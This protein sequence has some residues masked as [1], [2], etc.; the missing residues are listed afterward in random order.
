MVSGVDRFKAILAVMLVALTAM[1]MATTY[2]LYRG[3]ET[4]TK[5]VTISGGSGGGGGGTMSFEASGPSRFS[6]YG[7]LAQ[8]LEA[9]R[10]VG[11]A[12]GMVA[13]P[14]LRGGVAEAVMTITSAIKTSAPAGAPSY[15]KTNVQVEGI[16]EADIVKT[17][18]KRIYVA[19]GSKVWIIKAYPPDRMSVEA[20]IHPANY[21]RVRGL[22][23]ADGKLVVLAD[24][25]MKIMPLVRLD[26]MVA[27]LPLGYSTPSTSILVYSVPEGKL[28]YNVTLSG[29]YVTGRLINST[30]YVVAS[31]PVMSFNGSLSVPAVNGEPLPPGKVYYFP[32]QMGMTYTLVAGL[33][34][35]TGMHDVT[36]LL[37]SYTSRIYMSYSNLYVVSSGY[38]NFTEIMVRVNKAIQGLNTTEMDAWK[39]L[40]LVSELE[41]ALSNARSYDK[42]VIYRFAVKG[43]AVEPEASTVLEGRILDQFSI[44]E[45][46]GYLRVAVTIGGWRRNF[47]N[48]LY[49]LR[50]KDL[51]VAGRLDGLAEG[52]RIYAARFMGKL[53]FLVT[54]RQMDP[55]FAIDLSNP[56]KPRVLG[57]LKMPGYSEYLHPYGDHYL[58]GVGLTDDH[59]VKLAVFDISDP[60]HPA[61]ISEVVTNYTYTPVLRDHK[62]FTINAEKGYLLIPV[63]WPRKTPA[64]PYKPTGGVL[65]VDVDN[66]T[67]KMGLRAVLD[68]RDAVRALY[69]D[70]AIYSVSYRSVRAFD[71]YGQLIAEV[72]LSS[73]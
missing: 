9:S 14:L 73:K 19:S 24:K 5:T 44:D 59:R 54:Y 40:S 62:A 23:I 12:A 71:A 30:L 38:M 50:V 49:V 41:R 18:G 36:A 32:E 7:Q 72:T 48:T 1:G 42:T 68:H 11:M 66:T 3:T 6:S 61:K 67:G 52:E 17:D 60:A 28:L 35:G 15:S 33:D 46:D 37:T 39:A 31:Q 27:S 16:D 57:Y 25:G 4:V 55:L 70:D 47:T 8:Y 34:L 65:V 53:C 2:T 13:S 43:L 29:T 45:A 22:F 10:I 58:I 63:A 26:G 51:G 64:G 56:E 21:S 69:I 20:Y